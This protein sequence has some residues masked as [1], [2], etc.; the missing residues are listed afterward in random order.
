MPVN[1]RRAHCEKEVAESL[2]TFLASLWLSQL[3]LTDITGKKALTSTE[4]FLQICTAEVSA[5]GLLKGIV[6]SVNKPYQ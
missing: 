1:M 4:I 2:E 3:K 5:A 6:V